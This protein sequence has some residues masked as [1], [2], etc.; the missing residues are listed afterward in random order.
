MPVYNGEQYLQEAV[1]SILGQTF[2]DFELIVI[3]DG[4][5]DKTAEILNSYADD[6]LHI[7]NQ[8]ANLKICKSLNAGIGLACGEYIAR[9]D[10]DD[11]SLPERFARQ[12]A[13]LDNHPRIGVLGGWARKI[14][15]EGRILG[16]MK[17]HTRPDCVRWALCFGC[18]LAHPSVMMRANIVKAAGGYS[19]AF[20]FAED[21]DLWRRLSSRTEIVNLAEFV[22]LH[23][24]H[25]ENVSKKH[26]AQ[27]LAASR[28]TRELVLAEYI[29]EE[30]A[31]TF[32][33]LSL[34]KMPEEA[35]AVLETQLLFELYNSFK[36]KHPMSFLSD[37]IVRYSIGAEIYRRFYPLAASPLRTKR[38]IQSILFAPGLIKPSSRRMAFPSYA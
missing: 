6:R 21:Y 4:S 16:E 24:Q 23:R 1:N 8:P 25:S 20:L 13:Y 35:S 2:H 17:N 37:R 9:M 27:Q 33:E 26:K 34:V 15:E 30:K 14:T 11:I 28:A 38:L 10:A 12:V 31:R 3:N 36:T 32:V 29:G 22:L 7:I 5:T 19:D 18:P